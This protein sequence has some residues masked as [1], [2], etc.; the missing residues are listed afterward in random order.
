MLLDK[1]KDYMVFHTFP[2][3]WEGESELLKAE[4]D[5]HGGEIETSGALHYFPE[6]VK[7]DTPGDYGL[8][9]KRNA[10]YNDLDLK[11]GI[12]WYADHPGHFAADTTKGSAE[13]GKALVKVRLKKMV[14]QIKLVKSDNTPFELY[15]EF[16]S[17][18]QKP[19]NNF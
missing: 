14:E 7:S 18:I 15:N 12:W 8:S 4:A 2:F 11:S 19:S 5:G 9:L 1:K 17:R 3:G 13:K 16:H 10:K 6:L